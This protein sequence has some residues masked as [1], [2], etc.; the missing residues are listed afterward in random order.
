MI[1]GFP[2]WFA[3]LSAFGVHSGGYEVTAYTLII[4][5]FVYGGLVF[6]LLLLRSHVDCPSSLVVR[7]KT[8]S[9]SGHFGLSIVD[10]IRVYTHHSVQPW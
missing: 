6:L 9:D 4:N 8:L 1:L 7:F 10:V 5:A 3:A 2:G